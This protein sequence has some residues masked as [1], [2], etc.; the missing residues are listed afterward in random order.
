[1]P[2]F[3]RAYARSIERLRRRPGG[4]TEAADPVPSQP[5]EPESER[6]PLRVMPRPI[7]AYVFYVDAVNNRVGRVV[8]YMIFVMIGVLLFTAISRY[9]FNTPY[10]WAVEVS[11]FLMVSYYTL[12][13]GFSMQADAHVRMDA[14]YSRWTPRKRA[15][16]DSVTAF[17]LVFYLVWLLVGGFSSTFYSLET[18]QTAHSA[19]APLMWPVKAVMTLGI[20][21][22]LLQA[23]ALFFRDIAHVTGR[24]LR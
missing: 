17:A 18:G 19:W 3:R 15:F 22:T 1:M 11:Q 7:Q 13:G 14:L 16:T 4:L 6:G 24:Q 10:I 2:G 8:M 20:G 9:F 21:L 12:G 5:G 23:I